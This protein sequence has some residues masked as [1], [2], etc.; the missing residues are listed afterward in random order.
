MNRL[1]R[2]IQ[3]NIEKKPLGTKTFKGLSM[4]SDWKDKKTP[5]MRMVGFRFSGEKIRV[6]VVL[7]C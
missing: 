3:Q 4:E 1:L 2:K 5:E 6:S 7:L